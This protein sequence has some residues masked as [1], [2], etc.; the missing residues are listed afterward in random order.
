MTMGRAGQ[1]P[2][3]AAERRRA[4]RNGRPRQIDLFDDVSPAVAPAWRELPEETRRTLTGLI[5]RLILEYAEANG[6][7]RRT[8]GS[9]DL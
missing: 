2:A 6:A 7:A 3:A 9:D 8:E 5:A 1:T 4:W